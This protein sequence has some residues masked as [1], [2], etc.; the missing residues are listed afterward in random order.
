MKHTVLRA[1]FIFPVLLGLLLF[2]AF[3]K[4]QFLHNSRLLYYT[5]SSTFSQDTI[6]TRITTLKG[7]EV[8]YILNPGKVNSSELTQVTKEF[9]K[10]GFLLS[11]GQN[12]Q[13]NEIYELT[14]NSNSPNNQGTVTFNLRDLRD[15][16][17]VIFL[18]GDTRTREIFVN[19]GNI[20]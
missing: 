13:N 7:A 3:G 9:Q 6:K 10:E 8:L 19:A 1:K 17:R 16:K 20:Q 2:K 12:F 18:K 14:I 4:E 5:D 11:F 15:S